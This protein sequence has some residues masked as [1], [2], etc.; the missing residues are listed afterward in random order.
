MNRRDLHCV[1]G[2]TFITANAGRSVKKK[3]SEKKR[4]K[5]YVEEDY[6]Q[7]RV[8]IPLPH[9]KGKIKLRLVQDCQLLKTLLKIKRLR[10]WG[11]QSLVM[12][13]RNIRNQWSLIFLFNENTID[14][15]YR[16]GLRV[17]S[18]NQEWY[19]KRLLLA[20]FAFFCTRNSAVNERAWRLWKYL[21]GP[22]QTSNFSWDDPNSHLGRPKLTKIVCWVRRRT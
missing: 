4:S 13:I 16:G 20:R 8:N 6:N 15:K 11:I 3:L 10:C 7:R 9:E 17:M 14:P 12:Q 18:Y 19:K 5:N 1:I 22:G 2:F 21:L